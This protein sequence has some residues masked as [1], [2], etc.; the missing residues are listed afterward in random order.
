MNS[1][2]KFDCPKNDYVRVELFP[3]FGRK[4]KQWLKHA[5]RIDGNSAPKK[6]LANSHKKPRSKTRIS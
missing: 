6:I 5:G 1:Y 3:I 2:T 4:R